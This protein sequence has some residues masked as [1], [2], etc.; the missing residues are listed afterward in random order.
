MKYEASLDKMA[1]VITIIITILFAAGIVMQ[2]TMVQE[3]AIP[4]I[5]SVVLVLTYLAAYV[6]SP[7]YYTVDRESL[8]IHRPV[9]KLVISRAR[10]QEVYLMDKASTKGVIRT[11]GVG[12]LFGYFGRFSGY[13]TG[14]MVWHATRRKNLVMVLTTE[15]QKIVVTP[16]NWQAFINDLQGH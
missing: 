8:V 9:G 5:V 7:L 10:I 6:Y 3:T 2:Y 11:F 4:S 1:L 13:Y 15:G 14:S 12:G 16:D